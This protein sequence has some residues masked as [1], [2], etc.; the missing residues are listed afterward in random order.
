[1]KRAYKYRIYPTEEQKKHFS[2]CFGAVRWFY[3]YALDEIKTHY[4]EN[5]EKIKAKEVKPLTAKYNIAREL[6]QLKK[7]EKTSWLGLADSSCLIYASEA[8][9]NAYK[10]FFKKQGGYPKS[11]SP[12]YG[13]SYTVQ[14][15]YQFTSDDIDWKNGLVRIGKAG[16]VKFVFHRRFKGVVKA[17]TVS[18][19]SYDFYE[20]SILVDDNFTPI[21]KK[22]HTEEGTI[23]IDL[24]IKSDGNAILS[25]G[26]KFE[27]IKALKETKRIKRLQKKLTKKQW[28][29]TGEMKFSKKYGKDVEVKKPSKNYIKLKDKIA[30]LQD[31]IARKRSYNTHAITSYVTKNDDFDT[32]AIENLNVKGMTKNHY[33][34]NSVSNANMGEIKRQIEYK[35]D[36]YGKNLIQVDRFYPSSQICSNCGYQNKKLKDLKIRKWVCPI[37]GSEHDRDVNAAINMK[38]E[39]HRILSEGKQ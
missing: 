16:F 6:P 26:T 24:G 21:N 15:N 4:E 35:C 12:K 25:D 8:L 36:W 3:N 17:I 28:I 38:K 34:A 2:I 18:K 13:K 10:K 20:A 39:G 22:E 9:D 32:V 7:E 30:K 14:I 37:C 33:L 31:K 23:G 29:K 19:K 11:K 5:K 1:M 27:T